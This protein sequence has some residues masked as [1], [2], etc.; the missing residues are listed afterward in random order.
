M[1]LFKNVDIKDID[2]ILQKGILSLNKCGNDNWSDCGYGKRADNSRD[3]VYLFSPI[4]K[5]NAFPNYGIALI[6]VEVDN[7]TENSIS[8][9]DSNKGKY[10]E[11]IVEEVAPDQ[12]RAIYIPKIFRSRIEKTL[13]ADA[14]ALIKWCEISATYYDEEDCIEFDKTR[15]QYAEMYEKM[16][17]KE[18]PLFAENLPKIGGLE[19]P[20]E[21]SRR[22]CSDK[23][24]R[25]FAASTSL[26][27]TDF[28][29]F[30]GVDNSHE[31]FDIYDI[32][33][34]I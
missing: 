15:Q 32:S 10:K 18:I 20:N 34:T 26:N 22:E 5:Y 11:F 30:R 25:M 9:Y 4:S 28:N 7:V 27:S 29:F 8:D 13:S 31:I 24:L 3:V 21:I 1:T 6:E 23:L 2:S 14:L 19:Y 16:Y 33:Y 12:I 17:N